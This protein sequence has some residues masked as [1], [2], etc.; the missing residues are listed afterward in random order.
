MEPGDPT[1]LVRRGYDALS[2]TYEDAYPTATKYRPWLDDLTGRLRPDSTVVDLGCGC[3]VPVALALT[4]AGHRVIGV[5]ISAVQVARARELVPGAEF[6][7]ADLATVDFD[8]AGLDAVVCLYALIHVPVQQHP[9]VLGRIARWLAPGGELLC[10]LGATEWT[11]VQ[12]DWL[13]GGLPMWWSHADAATN[14]RW[15][16]G[17]GLLVEHEEFVPEGDSGAVLFRARAGPPGRR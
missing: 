12:E 1:D 11:G 8:E 7:C 4:R 2:R 14:R 5:D 10:T 17:A 3:G 16:A 15:L 6:R 13:G 9:T